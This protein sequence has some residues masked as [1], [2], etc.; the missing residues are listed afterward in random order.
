MKATKKIVGA[1]CALVAAVALSAGSTFAWFAANTSVK[2]TGMSVSAKS[3]ATYLL[4]SG[5]SA[6]TTQEQKASLT[7]EVTGTKI[8]EATT[9]YPVA[10]C[11]TSGT[12]GGK[13]DLS[14]ESGKWYT[15]NNDKLDGTGNVTNITEVTNYNS[16]Y[17]LEY[18]VWLTLSTDSEDTTKSID[19]T[20]NKITG[21]QALSAVV[22]VGSTDPI[23]LNTTTA[24]GTTSSTITLKASEAVEVTIY[25]Y[26]D[27]TST[28]VNSNYINGGNSVTGTADITFTLHSGS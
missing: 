7:T 23:R 10:Y 6:C 21:D 11:S 15:A 28:N 5:T 17:F 19:V 2:A 4:I 22:I 26:I 1:A 20:F 27:G 25:L 3:N 18:N 12:L 16:S 24:T 9:C 13:T 14:V 8:G